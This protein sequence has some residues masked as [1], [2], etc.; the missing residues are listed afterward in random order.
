MDN[1]THTKLDGGV[2]GGHDMSLEV[3]REG[4]I[5]QKDVWVSV[6]AVEG[7]FKHPHRLAHVVQFLVLDQDHKSCIDSFSRVPWPAMLG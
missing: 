1:T 7:G 5:V 2:G 4:L 3:L 6:F